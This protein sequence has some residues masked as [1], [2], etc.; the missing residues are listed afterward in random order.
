MG[1]SL[2][3][4][5]EHHVNNLSRKSNGSV[6]KSAVGASLG[7]S[8][9][10]YLRSRRPL[11]KPQESDGSRARPRNPLAGRVRRREGSALPQPLDR[12]RL[13]ADRPRQADQRHLGGETLDRS[14]P[15]TGLAV[16]ALLDVVRP[17]PPAVLLGEVE[18]GEHVGLGLLRDSARVG[19]EPRDDFVRCPVG[20]QGPPGSPSSKTTWN[21]PGGLPR[22][23]RAAPLFCFTWI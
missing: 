2:S 9:E 22:S 20:R 6:A 15:A 14:D 12:G 13:A 16:A 10:P 17:Y 21:T 7:I 3:T 5:H 19:G 11:V 4:E 23:R 8:D 1:T 18:V